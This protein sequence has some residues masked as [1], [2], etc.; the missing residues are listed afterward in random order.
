MSVNGGANTNF[1][2]AV[3]A[4]I[5]VTAASRKPAQDRRVL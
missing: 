2:D 5:A 3:S 4:S 1:A